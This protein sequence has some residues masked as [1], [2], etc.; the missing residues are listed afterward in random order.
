MMSI[1][2]PQFYI[3]PHIRFGQSQNFAKFD[4]IYVNS[5]YYEY[6]LS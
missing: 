1:I 6:Y 5:F 4:K 3:T 2:L